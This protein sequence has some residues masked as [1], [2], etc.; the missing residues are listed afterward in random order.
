MIR[1]GELRDWAEAARLIGVTRARMTQIANLTL[2][3]P[4][5]QELIAHCDSVPPT[6]H[7]LR[8]IQTQALWE[9]QRNNRDFPQAL[10][11][12]DD[13]HFVRKKEN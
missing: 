8:H 11:A 3:A 4:E 6:E 1:A 7:S 2:L 5:I 12:L 13:A 10:S 9:G